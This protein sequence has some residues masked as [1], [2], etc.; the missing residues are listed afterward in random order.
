MTIGKRIGVCL[1][2]T[3]A[4]ALGLGGLSVY[5]ARTLGGKV[6]ELASNTARKAFV[7]GELKAA[8]A[9]LLGLER[10]II[11]AAL[12]QDASG[13]QQ[14]HQQFAAGKATFRSRHEELQKLARTTEEQQLASRVAQAYSAA[15]D[16]HESF[17]RMLA[18]Q[19]FQASQKE[20]EAAAASLTAVNGLAEQLSRMEQT[21]L[22]N[23]S[24]DA[25]SEVS[26]AVR[27]SGL[28][29]AALLAIGVA[30]L[31]VLRNANRMLRDSAREMSQTAAQV[32]AAAGQVSSASQSLAEG[33]SRQ[34]SSIKQTSSA[35]EEVASITRQNT[36]NVGK[37]SG[38]MDEAIPIIANVNR[39]H[40]QL[41]KAMGELA[42]SSDKISRIIQVIDGIAFQTN[43][44]ALNAAVEAARAGEAGMGFA[45]VADE[46]RNLAQRSAAAA[47]ET[48]EL[49]EQS[50]AQSKESQGR[51][52][53]VLRA[54]EA[55]NTISSAM[56]T[57]M[58]EV[59]VGSRE[60]AR[61]LDRITQSVAQIDEI[62]QLAAASAEESA[63][64]ADEMSAQ[65]EA[66][67]SVVERLSALVT[68][69]EL[70]RPR[71][72]VRRQPIRAAATPSAA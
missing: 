66:M 33:A 71:T 14:R 9:D 67:M 50:V 34:A 23:A 65:A 4:V 49:I 26:N 39:A 32:A 38:L 51:L 21:L 7:A 58:D 64:A 60:Q 55:N 36:E 44:L 15:C 54:M 72:A 13:L 31:F 69:E 2:L 47:K 12:I 43:I 57:H 46:V 18:G 27:I 53:D 10:G 61:G 5:F 56:K 20:F 63:S 25:A 62:T 19:D 24:R 41:G 52:A 42:N 3:S 30:V 40:E 37:V 8:A 6:D 48:A 17:V 45:V 68:E 29:I 22:D 11:L 28:S 70:A 35:A 59:A 1:G 16:R